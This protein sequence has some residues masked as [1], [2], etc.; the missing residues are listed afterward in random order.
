MSW[1]PIDE[2]SP[3]MECLVTVKFGGG[4]KVVFLAYQIGDMDWTPVCSDKS[5]IES[6]DNAE[7]THWMHP[8]EPAK[9]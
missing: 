5:I 6:L 7:V 2:G 3:P 9:D 1:T 4:S 8:P